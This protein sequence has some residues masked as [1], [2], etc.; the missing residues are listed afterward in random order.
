MTDRRKSFF[1]FMPLRDENIS[2]MKDIARNF[3]QRVAR[4][5][6]DERISEAFKKFVTVHGLQLPVYG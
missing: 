1:L 2:S 6:R 5:E 3:W 4:D